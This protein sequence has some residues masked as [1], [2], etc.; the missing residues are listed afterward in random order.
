MLGDA[1]EGCFESGKRKQSLGRIMDW[2]FYLH[3][4]LVV[5]LFVF[6]IYILLVVK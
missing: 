5:Q 4:F 1:L 2:L 3:T 6:M